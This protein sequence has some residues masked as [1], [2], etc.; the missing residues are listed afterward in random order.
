MAHDINNPPLHHTTLAICYIWLTQECDWFVSTA[1][2]RTA[3]IIIGKMDGSYISWYHQPAATSSHNSVMI[4]KQQ[5]DYYAGGSLLGLFSTT[6]IVQ[7]L[8]IPPSITTQLQFWEGYSGSSSRRLYY[9]QP[10]CCL[11]NARAS[12]C[13]RPADGEKSSRRVK[14]VSSS[15]IMCFGVG[16]EHLLT[17]VSLMVACPC[18]QPIVRAK[19]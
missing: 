5:F 3:S 12:V 13:V 18:H 9:T 7:L 16:K 10:R 14:N 17:W 6:Q 8:T 2:V 1:Y 19:E 4:D 11:W 15:Y